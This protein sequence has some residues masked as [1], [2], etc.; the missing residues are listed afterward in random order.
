MEQYKTP[1]DGDPKSTKNAR[2]RRVESVRGLT[3]LSRNDFAKKCG[4]P[5]G[6]F[7]NWETP[8]FGGLTEKAARRIT[9]A[10]KSFGVHCS[11]E[12]LMFGIDPGPITDERLYLDGELII[13]EPRASYLTEDD[14]TTHIAEEVLLF[15]KH[16]ASSLDYLVSNDAM[17]PIYK[18]GDY[19]AG[20][21][22]FNDQ[23][24]S[25]IDLDCIIKTKDGEI[26]LRTLKK[27]TQDQRYTLTCRNPN[28]AVEN[29]ILYDIALLSV[30]PVIWVR[31][32]N[33]TK[34][35]E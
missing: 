4:I 19:T 21:A 13:K 34:L 6:S 30:A 14:Q 24:D 8:R 31:R 32:R 29:S 35:S 1:S 11:I 18:S 15:R 33:H 25:C 22:Y 16:H 9:T 5:S 26:M 20:P 7:Q 23:I 27:G 12:W 10:I 3:R 28:T 2:A 17:E